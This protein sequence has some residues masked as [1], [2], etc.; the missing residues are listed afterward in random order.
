MLNAH[1]AHKALQK[2]KKMTKKQQIFA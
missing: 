1:F 2:E